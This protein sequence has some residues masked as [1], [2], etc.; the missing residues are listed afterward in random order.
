[1]T[2]HVTARRDPALSAVVVKRAP[3]EFE[4]LV[5]GQPRTTAVR[6]ASS[7]VRTRRGIVIAQDDANFVAIYNEDGTP[8]HAFALPSGHGGHRHFDEKRGG[9]K[10]KLDLEGAV[11]LTGAHGETLLQFGSG[12]TRKREHV[13][14]LSGDAERPDVSLVHAPLLYDVLR[15]ATSFAGT[16]LNIEGAIQVEDRVRLFSRGNGPVR[17]GFK[18]VNASCD[19]RMNALLTHLKDPLQTDAPTP[20]NIVQYALGALEGIPLGF[21]DVTSWRGALYYSAAAED[22]PDAVR[23]GVVPGSAIG[24][25]T[26]DRARWTAFTHPDG[27]L[28]NAKVEGLLPVLGATNDLYVVIDS[29]SADVPSELCTVELRGP[30]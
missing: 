6:S 14:I 8:R 30:W 18:P 15:R 21:T 25:I 19:L 1:M 20:E 9:K 27:S 12:S 22:S 5:D 2:A 16:D 17:D 10:H 4:E 24:V 26:G 23:D 7:I 3:L 13:A 29:D 28:F 11:T